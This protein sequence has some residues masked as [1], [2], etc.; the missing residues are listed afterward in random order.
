LKNEAAVSVL[1]GSVKDW[2]SSTLLL[3][4]AVNWEAAVVNGG[5][6]GSAELSSLSSAIREATT[7]KVDS[8][9]K[10]GEWK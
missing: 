10:S 5:V 7:R 1:I 4:A 2:S 3:S 8:G 6:N 9:R